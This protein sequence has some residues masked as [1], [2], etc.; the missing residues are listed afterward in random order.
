MVETTA[1][2]TA[3]SRFAA[4]LPGD[5]FVPPGSLVEGEPGG[6]VCVQGPS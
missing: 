1:E 5:G 4:T 2:T 6:F 3:E